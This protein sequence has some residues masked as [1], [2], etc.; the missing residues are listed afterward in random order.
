MFVYTA[1]VHFIYNK[2]SGVGGFVS[3]GNHN[4]PVCTRAKI[5]QCGCLVVFC[6]GCIASFL[7]GFI[8]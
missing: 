4:T 6:L 1:D 3:E 7:S 8:Q 2:P 5:A